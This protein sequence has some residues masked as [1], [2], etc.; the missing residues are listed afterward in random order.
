MKVVVAGGSGFIGSALCASLDAD[1]HETV[2]VSR[3]PGGETESGRRVGW[4]QVD[5]AVDGADAVVNLAGVPIGGPR[6]TAGRKAAIGLSRVETTRTLA[7]AIASAAN[8]PVVFVTA[9]GID[10]YGNRGE[11]TVDEASSVGA[12]F[13]AGVCESWEAAAAGAEPVRHVAIRTPLVVGKGAMSVRLMALPFR[14]FLGG[15][16]GSGRQWFSWV[17]LDDLVRIYRLA[18]ED[19]SLGGVVNAVAPEQLR[20]RDA[21]KT[22]GAVLHR[23]SLL[24]AP[25]LALRA[26]LGEQAD[27][28]LHGRRAVSTQLGG[29]EFEYP[30]LR[31]ALESAFS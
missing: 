14:L 27:L 1:G 29:F 24:P 6:W 15:P 10:Y 30:E 31:G 25:A 20:Q 2:V 3:A 19:A 11:E 9:S 28:L 13:L 21:A 23:P 7:D 5:S 8:P 22:F 4:Q 12:S 16:L 17:A 26:A 18:I